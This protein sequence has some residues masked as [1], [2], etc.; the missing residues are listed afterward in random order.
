[1]LRRCFFEVEVTR[2]AKNG[3]RFTFI[4]STA[5]PDR[6]GDIVVQNWDLSEF[7]KNPVILWHHDHRQVIGRGHDPRIDDAGRLLIDVEFDTENDADPLA[8]S[9]AHKVERGFIKA[10]SVGF[11]PGSASMRSKYPEDSEYH[12]EG[13]AGW[14]YVL[15]ADSPNV[16][17]EFSIVSLGM[18]EEAQRLRSAQLE[19]RFDP[20]LMRDLLVDLLVNDPLVRAEVDRRVEMKLA[21]ETDTTSDDSLEALFER[22][23]QPT[24]TETEDDLEAFLRE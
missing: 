1:M 21:D 22:G 10:G 11:K 24:D 7:R 20:E 16:L 9:I 6:A 13:E 19:G 5:T 23:E 4:A 14:G 12:A 8:R 2:N 15:G 18:N 17:R 3:N